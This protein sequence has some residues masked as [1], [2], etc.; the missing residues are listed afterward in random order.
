MANQ[1]ALDEA[2]WQ[3]H[4]VTAWTEMVAGETRSLRAPIGGYLLVRK[5]E[6]ELSPWAARPSLRG[7]AKTAVRG[8]ALKVEAVTDA[9]VALGD[10]R[11]AVGVVIDVDGGYQSDLWGLLGVNEGKRPKARYDQR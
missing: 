4:A 3:H 5:G 11:T 6:V 7:P 10:I 9:E 1:R 8:G 2:D